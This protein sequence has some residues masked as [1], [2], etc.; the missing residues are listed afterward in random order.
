MNKLILSST[1]I[2]TVVSCTNNTQEE[3]V[4][5]QDLN[6]GFTPNILWISCEDISPYLGCYGDPV[7][8][9]PNIDALASDGIRFTRAYTT[10]GVSAPS[11]CATIT[12][13]Y[14]TSIGGHHMR[15][16]GNYFE[17]ELGFKGYSII[18]PDSVTCFSE[19]LR[20]A[21]YYTS[22]G[23][24]TDYQFESPLSAW[25]ENW[26]T[27]HW[28]K[29]AS[30]QPFFS[31]INLAISHESR[32]W[33]NNWYHLLVSPDSVDVPPYFPDTKEVRYMLARGY[34]NI[35]LMDAQVGIIISQ[36]EKENLL[37]STL[38]FFFSDHGGPYPRGKREILETGTHVPLIVRLPGGKY[39]NSTVDEL[40]SF[41][42][43]SATVLSLADINIPKS[44]QGQ[45]FMGKQK[46]EPRPYVF[47]ARDR[48]DTE[49]DRARAVR[50]KR[51]RYIRNYFPNQPYV[52]DIAYRKNIPAWKVIKE[53]DEQGKY[54]GV[55][56]LWWR[57]TKP[58]E[59]LYDVVNDPYEFNNL[60]DH[61]NYADKLNELRD[62]MD[63]WQKQYGD[64]GSLDEKEMISTW[65]NGK[66]SPPVTANPIISVENNQIHAVCN[67]KGSSM[68]YRDKGDKR[69]Q[70]YT[71]PITKEKS[72]TL[73]FIAVRIGYQN[74]EIIEL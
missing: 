6:L 21:G 48:M 50:D 34:S 62:A 37:D 46:A 73:E 41:V 16:L 31:V 7:A 30:G 66:D 14:Q 33:E 40:V 10:S 4:D 44:I 23:K 61:P 13:C 67:T 8:I 65:W 19:Y 71:K 55:Q 26:S 9:S 38:V 17:K 56:K 12:G 64:M 1:L 36:L 11:R 20:R 15:T 45:A 68:V 2:A 53:W 28:R 52:Q 69:W 35:A 22:N 39:A 70:L 51:Y 72:D 49:Y 59:E 24:K 27:D 43:L 3:K 25:D 32:L 18:P 58:V 47:A 42:D 54:K 29:R 74:S 57:D 60:A 63:N 5:L